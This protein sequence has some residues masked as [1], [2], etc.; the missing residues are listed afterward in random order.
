MK[1]KDSD[2][3]DNS[4]STDLSDAGDPYY[5]DDGYASFKEKGA[6]KSAILSGNPVRYLYWGIGIVVIVA[7]V[8]TLVLLFSNIGNP[9]DTARVE[10]LEKRIRNLEK[11]LEK[12]AAVDE[13]VTRIW[14][15]AKSF[16]TFKTRFDRSEASMSLRMDHLAMSLDSLQQ[17]TDAIMEKVARLSKA[18]AP[19]KAVTKPSQIKKKAAPKIHVVVAGDT[20]FNISQRYKLSVEKLRS[21]NGLNRSSVINIGQRLVVD[22]H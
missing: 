8:L 20:L 17:K 1:W 6:K 10:A 3:T 4:D 16:E 21:L 18:P 15:Q 22:A 19:Q 11:Q 12:Y 7:V 13:K 9:A 5:E 2:S 14:E